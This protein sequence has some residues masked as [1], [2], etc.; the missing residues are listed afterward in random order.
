MTRAWQAFEAEVK[1]WHEGYW[2]VV[3]NLRG[4]PTG[5]QFIV[6]DLPSYKAGK[7]GRSAYPVLLEGVKRGVLSVVG[8]R[9]KG[10]V[11]R[12]VYCRVD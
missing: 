3:E 11:K 7:R 12:I 2:P 1:T 9:P 5:H 10:R 8:R 6:D 4:L